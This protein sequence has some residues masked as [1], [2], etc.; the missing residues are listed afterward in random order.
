MICHSCR[1]PLEHPS[2][3]GCALMTKHNTAEI[4]RLERAVMQEQAKLVLSQQECATLRSKRA[5]QR[6]EIA[7]LTQRVEELVEANKKLVDEIK[8]MRGEHV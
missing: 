4:M 8:W 7:R 3:D 5:K 1:E 2:G 6:N